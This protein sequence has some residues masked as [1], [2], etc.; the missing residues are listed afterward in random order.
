VAVFARGL[1]LSQPACMRV[2]SVSFR[3]KIIRWTCRHGAPLRIDR[4]SKEQE[5]C[6]ACKKELHLN[7]FPIARSVRFSERAK[8]RGRGQTEASASY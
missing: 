6:E 5:R 1:G 3:L 2:V 4:G 8:W 7:S